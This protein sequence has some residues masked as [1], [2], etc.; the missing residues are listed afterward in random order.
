MRSGRHSPAADVNNERARAAL[1]RKKTEA[2]QK[3]SER[4]LLKVFSKV[5]RSFRGSAAVQLEN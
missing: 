2:Q 5:L 4:C 3:S 1:A